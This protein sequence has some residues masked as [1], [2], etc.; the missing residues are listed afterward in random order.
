[1]GTLAVLPKCSWTPAMVLSSK[2]QWALGTTAK[3]AIFT[4]L[5]WLRGI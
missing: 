1:M 5:G 2:E 4:S 3:E